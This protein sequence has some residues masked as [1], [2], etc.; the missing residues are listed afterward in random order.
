MFT[1]AKIRNGSTYFANHLSANDYYAQGERVKGEWLGK[2]TESLGLSGEV[3]P[4]AFEALRINQRPGTGDRLT[5]RTKEMR[6]P[7]LARES[8]SEVRQR[9]LSR[10]F[11]IFAAD[12]LL[13]RPTEVEEKGFACG[14]WRSA[15]CKGP[16]VQ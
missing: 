7:T 10:I 3:R 16:S 13:P 6:Q 4:E 12:F 2:G 9:R 8:R 5:P 14:L 15:R 11:H 1:A